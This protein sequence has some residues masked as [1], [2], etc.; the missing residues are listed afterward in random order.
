MTETCIRRPECRLIE[1]ELELLGNER[2]VTLEVACNKRSA[3]GMTYSVD[4]G[5]V[6]DEV[7]PMVE[8]EARRQ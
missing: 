6:G 1:G 8:F 2:P 4:N 7:E 5:C 3:F